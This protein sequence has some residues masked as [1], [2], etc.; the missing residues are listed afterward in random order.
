MQELSLVCT[1]DGAEYKEY[2]VLV[3]DQPLGVISWNGER[4]PSSGSWYTTTSDGIPRYFSTQ[5]DV[6]DFLRDDPLKSAHEI[7]A[8]L[9]AEAHKLLDIAEEIETQ[10]R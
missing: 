5:K 4:D 8:K 2:E 9:K 7:S 3:N 10:E 1:L 6:I